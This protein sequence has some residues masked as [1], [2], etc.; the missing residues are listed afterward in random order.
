MSEIRFDGRVAVI[1]GAGHT[2]GRAYALDLAARGAA[3]V[4]ND[5]GCDPFGYGESREPAD[6]VVAEITAAGGKA[7]ASYDTVCTRAG[8]Q[9]IIDTAMK[10]YGRVDIV[11]SNAGILRN[12]PFEDL[13]DEQLD[14]VMDTHLMG[15]F[16]VCQPA[17]RIMKQRGY[18]RFIIVC[19]ASGLFG[20]P[21]QGNYAAAKAG[22]AGL[23][24]SLAIEG[25]Q[26]GI[27]ANGLLPTSATRLGAQPYEWPANY[28][29][30]AKDDFP[31]IA[32][33]MK[34]EFVM[35]MVT[36]L[37]S[38]NCTTTHG[39]YSATAARYARVF[40]GAAEGWLAPRGKSVRAEDIATHLGEIEDTTRFIQP[41]SV[42][43]EF[44][45]IAAA[46]RASTK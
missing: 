42:M 24:H 18:G 21:W 31:V 6:A 27:L 13:T 39:L 40:V 7:V 9:A 23:V 20:N 2:L 17:Y 37:A 41:H 26:Y 5:L 45:P 32:D 4:V 36:Y 38:E 15:A 8:G 1:T 10:A 25:K 43:Q 44:G 16:Y 34:P 14:G 46:I 30:E 19:S 35:P 12:A 28:L 3:V 29:E 22:L 11:I 33:T